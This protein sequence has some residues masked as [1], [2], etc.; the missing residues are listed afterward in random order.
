MLPIVDSVSPMFWMYAGFL[1][2]VAVFLVLDLGVFHRKT[3]VISMKEALGWTVVWVVAALAFNVLIY[4]AYENH[5]LGIGQ[6]V[7]QL[8]GTVRDV[9]GFEASKLYLAGYL[10]EKSLAMDNVFVI[11]IVFSYFAIPALYQ[12]RVLF[13]GIIGAL[14][15]RGAMI[16]LGAQLIREFDW[17][18]YVFCGFLILTGIKMA[19]AGDEQIDPAKNPVVRL[20]K[21]FVPISDQLDGEKFFTRVNGIRMATPLFLALVVV[22]FTDLIFAVDSIPAIFAITADP[23][24]VFTS[25]IFAILGLRSLYFCLASMMG[26]FRYLKP[27]LVAILLFV[28]VKMLL[29]HTKFKIDTGVSLGV[30]VGILCVGVIASL[31]KPAPS[32]NEPAKAG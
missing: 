12:H 18:I 29:V 22:E 4:F 7:P 9:S 11:A 14:L 3:H 8:D 24:L 10:V 31:L 15:M 1:A 13:W 25:N 20:V 23:F 2:L 26:K 17:I 16:A 5:W 6:A 27:S 32:G 28:G 21:K 19:F 30:V